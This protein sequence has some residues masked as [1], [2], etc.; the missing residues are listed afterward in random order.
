MRIFVKVILE[1]ADEKLPLTL[2][3]SSPQETEFALKD[4]SRPD[5]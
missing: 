1:L 2:R 5:N 3:E 4:R